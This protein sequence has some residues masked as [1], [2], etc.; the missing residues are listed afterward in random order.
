MTDYRTKFTLIEPSLGVSSDGIINILH[1][2]IQMLEMH[3]L[4]WSIKF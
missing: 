3:Y 2:C 4:N 1:S